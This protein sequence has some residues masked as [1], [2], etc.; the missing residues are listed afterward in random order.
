MTRSNHMSQRIYFDESGFT[1][2]NL[3]SPVQNYFAYASIATED[4]EAKDF[5]DELISQYGIQGGELKGGK[6]AVVSGLFR[7]DK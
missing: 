2:N 3:L 1:G 4:A 7:A 5:V 6:L